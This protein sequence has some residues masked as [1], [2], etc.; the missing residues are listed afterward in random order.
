MIDFYYSP[1]P[2]GWKVAIMLAET[3]LA[4][5]TVL[6]SLTDGEQL[7]PEFRRIN[8]NAKIPAIVDHEGDGTPVSVFESGAILMYLAEKAGK[9][10]PTNAAE[11]REMMQ[12]LFWQASNQGPMAGQLSHFVNYAPQ[13]QHY[14]LIRYRGEFERTL[15]VL[16]VRLAGRDY[17]LSTYSIVDMMAFPWAFIAKP[18]GIVLDRFPNVAAW[19]QRIKARPA[20]ISAIN[21]YKDAQFSGTASAEENTALFNQSAVHL[22]PVSA[23]G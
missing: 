14:G 18:L 12:W 20:V 6:M 16:D 10:L 19:R 4:H 22:R 7:S 8:P 11:Q 3:G 9:F 23:T 1:T 17:I 13:G 15:A 2:N 21:L 5:R